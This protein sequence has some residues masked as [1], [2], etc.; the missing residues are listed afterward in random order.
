MAARA[1]KRQVER[2]AD[3]LREVIA[4]KE[5]VL[6]SQA[7]KHSQRPD[8]VDEVLQRAYV[9]FL[10]RFQPERFEPVAWLQTT[11][12]REAWGI[13]ARACRRR[14]HGFE[15]FRKADGTAFD[16]AHVLADEAPSPAEQ[17]EER[18]CLAE[19]REKLS[20]LKPDE[21]SALLLFALG[22]SYAEIAELRAW[23]QTKV[24][25]CLAEGRAALR[26]MLAA[27]A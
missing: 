4:R 5:G 3:V 15:D 6:R 23:T 16:L 26:A 22:Y 7:R 14:E 24:N 9:L 25:R 11:V 2:N 10:E 20:E 18:L 17:A 8:D 13:A 19:R 21:R 27:E 12:K 1:E